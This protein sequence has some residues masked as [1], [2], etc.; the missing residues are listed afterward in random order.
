MT[1]EGA[2]A[3]NDSLVINA[4]GGNDTIDASAAQIKVV[5]DGGDGND[6]IIGGQG[7]IF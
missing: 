5:I 3:A 1:I 6:T 7:A 4:L 2:E